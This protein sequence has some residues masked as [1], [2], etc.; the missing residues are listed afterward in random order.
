MTHRFRRRF[1][2]SLI[3][4]AAAAATLM[5]LGAQYTVV[6]SNGHVVGTLVTD[7]PPTSQ[8]R[9]AG[10]ADAARKEQQQP[11]RRADRG[12]H[13]DSSKALTVEQ[14]M[15]SWQREWD[16]LNPPVVTGGG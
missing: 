1:V 13:P 10:L 7:T 9:V 5:A 4:A 2:K 12:F 3:Q 16:R 14:Q 8:L 11:D 15:Q 6:D